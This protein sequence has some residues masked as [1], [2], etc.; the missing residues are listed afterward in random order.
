MAT[1]Y[2]ADNE[3]LTQ[4]QML[5]LCDATNIQVSA[6]EVKQVEEATRGQ[7]SSKIWHE[8][9]H[10]RITA[11]VGSECLR[12]NVHS[13]A[14]SLLKRICGRRVA[15]IKVP[16]IVWG[17]EHEED[18]F[19]LFSRVLGEVGPHPKTAP[20]G[21]TFLVDQDV[22][23]HDKLEV[24]K[25][26]F[27]ICEERPHLGASPD[28]IASCGCCGKGVLEI[29]CPYKHRL[30]P[31]SSAL[32]DREFCLDTARRLKKNHA[33]YAQ[34]QMEM[35]VCGVQHGFFVVWTPIDCAIIR[36]ARDQDFIHKMIQTLD[37]LWKTAVLPELLTRKIENTAQPSASTSAQ[38]SPLSSTSPSKTI[39][40]CLCKT[41]TNL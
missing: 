2:K 14:P 29:K 30:V 36:I 11:S 41:S 39:L 32:A 8:Q 19:R 31:L 35:Y 21:T 26:G 33:Y 15:Q 34:I 3:A 40:Y 27:V 16:P 9:R 5:D 22:T 1:L 10:G 23:S 12:T 4:Q 38:P 24:G 17:N 13:P 37:V 20:T 6:A 28:G 7:S 25:S 18:A